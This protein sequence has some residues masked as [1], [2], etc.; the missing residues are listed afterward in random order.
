MD[1]RTF[2]CLYVPGFERQVFKQ[3]KIF[4]KRLKRMNNREKQRK[5]LLR[6]PPKIHKTERNWPRNEN[7]MHGF[8]KIKFKKLAGF[9]LHV[10]EREPVDSSEVVFCPFI[11]IFHFL[12]PGFWIKFRC[13][14]LSNKFGLP[15]LNQTEIRAETKFK[16][17]LIH[18]IK[19]YYEL[20]SIISNFLVKLSS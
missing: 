12:A 15:V 18:I 4:S 11:K 19:K 6:K 14:L 13:F 3:V 7:N 9:C 2:L 1:R 17:V 8:K 20:R 16:Q 10:I 5:I